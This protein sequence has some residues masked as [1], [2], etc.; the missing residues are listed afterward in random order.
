[1]N[2]VIQGGG[3]FV[4]AAYVVTAAVLSGYAASIFL[5]YRAEKKRAAREERT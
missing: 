4:I 2:G 1:V 3:E 5:R